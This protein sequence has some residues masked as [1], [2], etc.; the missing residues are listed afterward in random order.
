MNNL[1]L[2]IIKKYLKPFKKELT[3]G[4]FALFIVNIL[5]VIIPLEVKNIIDQTHLGIFEN[6][7]GKTND[8]A[9]EGQVNNILNKATNEAGQI[10]RS[11][12]DHDNRF[13][14]M[15]NAGSKGSDI[16]I[17][18]MVACLGQ[19]NVDGK[20]IPNGYNERAL[21][22]FTKYN[23]SPESRGFVENSFINGL[24]PQEF[25]FHAMGGREGLIDT[26]VK[27]AQTGYVQ[28]QLV[29]SMEDLKVGYD[30]SVRGSTG[31]IIQFVYG[32]DGMDGTNV[33]SLLQIK[34]LSP[35]AALLLASNLPVKSKLVPS[36]VKL[37]L[38]S[39]SPPDP[40]ITI[41]LSVKSSTL[42]VFA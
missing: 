12:L 11:S 14:I 13:V 32:N 40:A 42:N 41:R 4:V 33:E 7:T 38:S 21:P 24:T 34:I 23:V 19:Q 15:V 5:S 3:I 30:Y 6:K 10:G 1:K 31:S 26:A 20:R 36:N 22:H 37:A 35:K 28:R 9:F 17:A 29:K 39:N 8:Q 25:F 18:Q 27:T 16:N 2:N